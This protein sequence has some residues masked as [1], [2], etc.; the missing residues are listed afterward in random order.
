MFTSIICQTQTFDSC[1]L[2][3][4]SKPTLAECHWYDPH[5]MF[6][7]IIIDSIVH[8]KLSLTMVYWRGTAL[9][10]VSIYVQLI[11]NALLHPRPFLL[12]VAPGTGWD[13][14]DW[15]P[16]PLPGWRGKLQLASGVPLWVPPPGEGHGGEGEGALL[17]SGHNRE[18]IASAA[19]S[20]DLGQRPDQSRWCSRYCP[21]MMKITVWYII[22]PERYW[23]NT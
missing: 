9:L 14:E 20:S 23:A 7:L 1:K 4:P 15:C 8:M 16:L 22:E 13:P 21:Y 3:V 10:L 6:T 19:V 18:E 5:A 11:L 12:Q 17:Q 2:L